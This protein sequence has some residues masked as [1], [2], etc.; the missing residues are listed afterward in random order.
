M[1]STR[2][3]SFVNQFRLAPQRAIR[4]SDDNALDLLGIKG[5]RD[6]VKATT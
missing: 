1:G 6:S 4:M 5:L 2:A 3:G